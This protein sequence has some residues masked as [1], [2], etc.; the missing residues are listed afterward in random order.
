MRRT[1]TIRVSLAILLV[2]S[3]CKGWGVY[4]NIYCLKSPANIECVDQENGNFSLDG[5]F[6]Q[7]GK[8]YTFGARRPY[9]SYLPA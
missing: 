3:S 9:G 6:Q 1:R 8:N 5:Y 7:E 4:Q 2:F